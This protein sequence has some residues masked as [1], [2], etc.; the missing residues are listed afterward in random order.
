MSRLDVRSCSIDGIKVITRQAKADERGC[1]ERV[2]CQNELVAVT[3]G[4][5]ITQ[6]NYTQ[7]YQEGTVR[8]LHFQHFPHAEVKVVTCLKGRVWDVAVDLRRGSSTFLNHF[9][10]ELFE[11]DQK[12]LLIP[13]GCAHGFQTLTPHCALLY[14]HS[15]AHHPE[16]EGA[17]HALDPRLAI[18]WPRPITALSAKDREHPLIEN[19]FQGL[20][21]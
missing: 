12:S 19:D 18:P 1:L 7:T 16:A 10:I 17:V 20:D 5:I 9:A 21:V 15:A 2:Y 3:Q 4:E 6:I 13:E 14:L 11:G 8:G